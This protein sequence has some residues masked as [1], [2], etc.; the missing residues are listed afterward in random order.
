MNV[1]E[2]SESIGKILNEFL[3]S[4]PTSLAHIEEIREKTLAIVHKI[5]ETPQAAT[6]DYAA[7]CKEFFAAVKKVK[8]MPTQEIFG[9]GAS[10]SR[11]VSSSG[12]HTAESFTQLLP[13]LSERYNFCIENYQ[14]QSQVFFTEQIDQFQDLLLAFLGE[15]PVGGTKDKSVKSK[16]TEIKRELRALPDWSDLFSI[17][18]QSSFSSEIEYIFQRQ[19]GAI[20]AVWH[21]SSQDEEGEY[22]KTYDHRTQDKNTYAVRDNWAI[23]KGFMNAGPHG[24]SDDIIRPA[25]EIGCCCNFR[26]LYHLGDLPAAMLTYTGEAELRRVR[27]A[28]EELLGERNPRD[29][30]LPAP[31][32]TVKSKGGL[33]SWFRRGK[34]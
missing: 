10:R 14:E 23:A 11:L 4:G 7:S 29:K 31:N 26:Y 8:G 24:Y 3:K 34:A 33:M 25:Q 18:K 20:A 16:I 1:K 9:D 21:Y 19:G 27:Q 32:I 6:R 2:A 28:V 5:V 13:A 15:V 12:A 30:P 17:Y 22:K